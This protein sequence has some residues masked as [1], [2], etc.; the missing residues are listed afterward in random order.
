MA[1]NPTISKTPAKA[2]LDQIVDSLDTGTGTSVVEICSGAQPNDPDTGTPTVLCTI[3]LP[4]PVF[5]AATTGT[6]ADAGF[7]TATDNFATLTGTASGTGTASFFR[8]KNNSGVPKLDGT[9]GTATAD[10]IID[11]TSITSSQKVKI[12]SWKV[13][14]PYQ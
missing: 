14:L 12:T 6:G 8:A 5:A 3:N 9:V 11:N 10:M 7:I 13:R 4:D 2:A 1:T